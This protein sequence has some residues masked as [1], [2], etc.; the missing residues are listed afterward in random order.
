MSEKIRIRLKASHT[1][2]GK[3]FLPGEVISVY[4]DQV[5]FLI[6]QGVAEKVADPKPGKDAKLAPAS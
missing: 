1:D 5:E 2:G 4:P 3:D 6:Q